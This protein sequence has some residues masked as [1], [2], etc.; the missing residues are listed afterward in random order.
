MT[1]QSDHDNN[2]KILADAI[3]DR[4]GERESHPRKLIHSII[5][6]C[7]A[8]FARDILAQTLEIEGQGGM[9]TED[10]QRRRTSGGVFFYLAKG[11]MPSDVRKRLFPYRYERKKRAAGYKRRQAALAAAMPPEEY[12]K[13]QVLKAVVSEKHAQIDRMKRQGASDH[14]EADL[15]VLA[16][17]QRQINAIELKYD[18]ILRLGDGE[19]QSGM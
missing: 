11:Q 10:G 9:M 15:Q 7:G 16:E 14:L 13:Y 19:G 12:Q 5:E 2:T 18:H 6:R 17:T 3:A 1:E 4:L 8:A